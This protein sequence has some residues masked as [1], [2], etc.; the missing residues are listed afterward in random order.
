MSLE[1]ANK[2]L[3][4]IIL[5]LAIVATF[6][7]LYL[8]CT[9][10]TLYKQDMFPT[11]YLKGTGDT[12]RTG[13]KR[14]FLTI[15]NPLHE[16]KTFVVVCHDRN[17]PLISIGTAEVLVPARSDKDIFVTMINNQSQSLS[18]SIQDAIE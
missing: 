15:S 9:P 7:A 16:D 17:N 12:S 5:L 11:L 6:S 8:G 4:A 14:I 2:V 3:V 13:I 1:S 18:C 10:S